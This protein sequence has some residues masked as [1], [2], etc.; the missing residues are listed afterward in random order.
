MRSV[1][2]RKFYEKMTVNDEKGNRVFYNVNG[3]WHT[4]IMQEGEWGLYEISDEMF[5]H[6]RNTIFGKVPR[7]VIAHNRIYPK[8]HP[9]YTLETQLP[10]FW[11]TKGDN[12]CVPVTHKTERYAAVCHTELYPSDDEHC[13]HCH[14]RIPDK[15]ITI[16]RMLN[17]DCMDQ[18]R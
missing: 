4:E 5:S 7:T 1:T 9:I 17:A 6:N 2:D 13:H 15:F 18:T 14:A 8:T 12:E 16:W 10:V 3:R 11:D